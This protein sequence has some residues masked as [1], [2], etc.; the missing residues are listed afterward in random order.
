MNILRLKTMDLSSV[1]AYY[2]IEIN[3]YQRRNLL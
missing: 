1:A 2:Y 3:L